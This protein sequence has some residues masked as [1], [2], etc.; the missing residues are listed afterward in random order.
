MLA[1]GLCPFRHYPLGLVDGR[2]LQLTSRETR[3]DVNLSAVL[4]LRGSLV[5]LRD[6]G[7]PEAFLYRE[8]LELIRRKEIP[9][10]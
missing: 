1:P 5:G 6:G 7:A 9:G 3:L 2:V 8:I 10:L 4:G